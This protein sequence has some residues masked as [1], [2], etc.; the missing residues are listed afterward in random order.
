V[1][2]EKPR[3]FVGRAALEE[4]AK[5]DVPRVRVGLKGAGR[6]APRHGYRVLAGDTE[7]GEVTSGALSPTL[8]YPIAMAYVDRAHAEPG[9]SLSV[10]IRGRIE[11]VEV[12]ALPF[13][14]RA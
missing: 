2:F 6:R 13:Y 12:V 14:K 10:D 7:I 9:T 4:R 11:P 8:G 1:K 5:A 3:D